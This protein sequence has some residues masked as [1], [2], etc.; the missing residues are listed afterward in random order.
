MFLVLHVL[1][2]IVFL[3]YEFQLAEVSTIIAFEMQINDFVSIRSNLNKKV[4][5]LK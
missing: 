3:N 4:L 2:R 5:A 1:T